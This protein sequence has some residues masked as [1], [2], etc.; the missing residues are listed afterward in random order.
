M[1]AMLQQVKNKA[2]DV[3]GLH[4]PAVFISFPSS[5]D[6]TWEQRHPT[7]SVALV[8]APFDYDLVEH[9][10]GTKPNHRGQQYEQVRH[11]KTH[12]AVFV[13][14]FRGFID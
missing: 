11:A 8:I 10:S 14:A 6:S 9:A 4:L 1:P 12:P 2:V 5:K 3:E 13:S 7:S